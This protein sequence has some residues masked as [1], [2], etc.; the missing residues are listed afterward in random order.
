MK[1]IL[2]SYLTLFGAIAL[3]GVLLALVS[4]STVR[5]NTSPDKVQILSWPLDTIT[6]TGADTLLFSGIQ[7]SKWNAAIQVDGRQISGTQLLIAQ[8]QGSGFASPDADQWKEIARDTCNGALEQVFIDAGELDFV[9]YR[10]ILTGV[11]TMVA[12][13]EVV[14][15]LKKD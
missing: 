3:A 8:L 11:G 15:N 9:N 6:N 10:I 2:S 12:E 7:T 4:P 13:Y 1:N 14:A 5:Y